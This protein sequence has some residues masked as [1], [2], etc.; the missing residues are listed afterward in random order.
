MKPQCRTE[1]WPLPQSTSRP[2]QRLSEAT[3]RHVGKAHGRHS[4][5]RLGV[6]GAKPPGLLEQLD[7]LAGL[8]CRGEA[9][10]AQC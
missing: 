10:A 3:H 8:S 4:K 7:S 6:D 1:R 2:I 9:P 5:E